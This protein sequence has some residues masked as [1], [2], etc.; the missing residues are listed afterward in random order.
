MTPDETYEL[1]RNLTSPVVAITSRRGDKLNGMISDGV[2]R[3]SIVPDIPRMIILV[4]KIALSHEMIFATGKFCLHVL[5]DG[6][7]DVIRKL[8]FVSGR[9]QDKLADIPHTIGALGVPVLADHVAAFECEVLNAMDTGSS[10]CFLGEAKA[11]YRGPATRPMFPN[12]MRE[13]MPAEWKEYYIKNLAWAQDWARERSYQ[14]KR[15]KFDDA[16]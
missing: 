6:Q 11:V 12:Y 1:L 10:T 5:H 16:S 4:H 7:F 3:A 13:H 8:G 9:D 2:V 15:L 14:F